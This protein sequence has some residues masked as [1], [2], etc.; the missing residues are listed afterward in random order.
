ML[1]KVTA[2]HS[3]TINNFIVILYLIYLCISITSSSTEQITQDTN[4]SVSA[5]ECQ[6]WIHVF[7]V[8]MLV[9]IRIDQLLLCSITLC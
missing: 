8:W 2:F 4:V 7:Y 6:I 9:I 3:Y 5:L 1:L